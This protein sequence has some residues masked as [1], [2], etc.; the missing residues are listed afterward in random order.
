MSVMKRLK[1]RALRFSKDDR[2]AMPIEGAMA[3]IFLTWWYV[4]S[5]QFFDAYKQKNVN[6]KAAYAV[7]DLLSRETG[8]VPGNPNSRVIDMTYMQGLARVFDYMS[9]ARQPTWLRVTSVYW[10]G[11]QNRYEVA[12]SVTSGTGHG[13][14][15]DAKL[16]Q[17]KDKI[18][19]LRVGDTIILMET[20]SA[21]EPMFNLSM[22]SLG[23]GPDAKLEA[24]WDHNFITTRP[25]FAS[26]IPWED[27]GC[28]DDGTGAGGGVGDDVPIIEPDDPPIP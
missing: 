25:R 28:G 2:G 27:Q 11:T 14:M 9:F 12:W 26:C 18:P 5:V 15:N 13:A 24:R 19:N 20:F 3:S 22:P 1:L 17:V 6:Q 10:D 23:G 7:A 16:A 8:S 4:A 21:Y